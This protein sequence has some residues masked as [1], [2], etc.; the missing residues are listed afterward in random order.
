MLTLED[1]PRKDGFAQG[2]YHLTHK[3]DSYQASGYGFRFENGKT[4]EPLSGRP[5]M[6]LLMSAG[7]DFTIEAADDETRIGILD[8]L[9]DRGHT[10]RLAQLTEAFNV[11][12]PK[13]QDDGKKADDTE[14]K[15]ADTKDPASTQDDGKKGKKK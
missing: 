1:L 11:G 4:V 13:P 9:R 6:L 12:E 15:A 10:A 2:R 5:L 14:P 3:H 8:H 7:V